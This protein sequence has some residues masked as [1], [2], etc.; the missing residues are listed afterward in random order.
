MENVDD[1]QVTV[2]SKW[3]FECWLNDDI[4]CFYIMT[5]RVF[6]PLRRWGSVKRKKS[7]T[8]LLGCWGAAELPETHSRSSSLLTSF[9]PKTFKGCSRPPSGLQRGL[10]SLSA[11]FTVGS[12][13][14]HLEIHIEMQKTQQDMYKCVILKHSVVYK[15]S[16]RHVTALDRLAHSGGVFLNTSLNLW[17]SFF[18]NKTMKAEQTTATSQDCLR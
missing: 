12:H 13:Q 5:S 9:T 2:L 17:F 6:S 1:V 11:K 10:Q 8:H 3:L 16:R 4:D 14:R 15:N 7:L 18:F